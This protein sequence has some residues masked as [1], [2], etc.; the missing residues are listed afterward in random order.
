MTRPEAVSPCHL[1]LPAL[2]DVHSGVCPISHPATAALRALLASGKLGQHN[3]LPASIIVT[4]TLHDL[5]TAAGTGL[6]GGHPAAHLRCDPP[7]PPRPPLPG[8]LRPRQSPGALSHQATRLPRPTN[9]ALRQRM[10]RWRADQ[11][12]RCDR[13]ESHREANAGAA[14]FGGHHVD[15]LACSE[16]KLDAQCPPRPAQIT[17]NLGNTTKP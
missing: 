11:Q 8:D 16:P 15:F 3:G 2:S 6:T 10:L 7:G 5:E 4:T 13:A 12:Q 9:R 17:E 14:G 1:R